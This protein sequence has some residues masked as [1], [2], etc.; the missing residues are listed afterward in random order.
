MLLKD[1]E[2]FSYKEMLGREIK[3]KTYKCINIGSNHGFVILVRLNFYLKLQR[4]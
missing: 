2:K 3:R 4:E 1:K